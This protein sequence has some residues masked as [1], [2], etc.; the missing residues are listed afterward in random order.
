MRTSPSAA[1]GTQAGPQ[2]TL[3]AARAV[4]A[5]AA[6]TGEL[7]VDDLD[8]AAELFLCMLEGPSDLRCMVNVAPALAGAW[9]EPRE[10]QRIE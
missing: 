3:G 10:R 4:I 7:A 9:P 8:H 1:R 6:A 2:K 5:D